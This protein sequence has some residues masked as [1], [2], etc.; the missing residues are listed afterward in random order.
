MIKGMKNNEA[1]GT[2]HLQVQSFIYGGNDLKNKMT[3]TVN[4]V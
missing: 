3:E 2:D 1:T 4:I